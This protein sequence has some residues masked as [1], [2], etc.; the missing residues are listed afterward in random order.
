MAKEDDGKDDLAATAKQSVGTS[1]LPPTVLTALEKVPDKDAKA[2][3]QV[4]LSS[5]RTSFGYGPDPETAKILTDGEMHEEKCKLQAYEASL[6][7]RDKQNERD[8]DFR[9][10]K[11]NRE[12][13]MNL[14][15][16]LLGVV[17][18]GTGLYFVTAGNT[19]IGSNVLI[20][21]IGVVLY[22]L[23]GNSDLMKS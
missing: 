17:G 1:P 15:V 11:L 5:S 22:V 16:L 13:T 4:A 7:N 23:K 20:A 21:S 18:E 6:V 9:K 10:R 12:F 14:S 19:T 8:H 3:L 2:V